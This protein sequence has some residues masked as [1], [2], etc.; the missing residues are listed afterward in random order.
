MS[1]KLTKLLALLLACMM[2]ATLFAG[3]KKAETETEQPGDTTT[4]E[5]ANDTPLVVAYSPFSEKFSPFFAD[6][7]Y[8]VDAVNMTQI[9]MLTTDRMGGIIYNAIDGEKVNYNGTDYEYKGPC[10]VTVSYD[11]SA[12]VTTYTVKLKEGIKFSDGTEATADDMLFTYYVY[13]DPDYVG[14]TTLNSYDI[15]G[16]RNYQTQTTDDIYDKYNSMFADIYAA[17]AN[18][19]VKGGES[20][21][22][23]Q[24]DLFWKTL[25]PEAWKSQIQGL[26]DYVY[27]NYFGDYWESQMPGLTYSDNLKVAF[28]MVMWGFGTLENNVLTATDT[29]KTWDLT[30]AYPSI[31]DLYDE[32]V[33]KYK[34]DPEAYF[35][36]EATGEES[37]SILAAAQ[38]NFISQAGSADPGMSGGIKS[39]SGITK[40]DNYTI[41]VKT[42]GYSAP[43]VY[44]ICG[45]NITPMHYYGDEKQWDPDNG[46]Y[47]HPFGDLSIVRG[48][49]TTP[50]GAG[51]YKFVKYENK[52]I[53]YEANENYWRGTPKIK[54]IQ[55]KETASAEVASAVASG[56]VDAGE[57][58]GSKDRFNEVKSFNSNAE[59][60]GDV[61]TTSKVDNLG[62]G[63]IGIN[64]D[65]VNVGGDQGSEASKNL[66]KALATVLAVY[67]DSAYDSYYGEAASVIQYPISNTSWAAPQPTDDGYRQ[68]YSVDAS[69]KDIYTSDMTPDQ[70]YAAAKT[71]ALGFLEAAGYTVENGKA[72][73]AP[74]GARL[75]YEVIIPADGQGDH[76]SFA[77]LT[78]AQAALAE[79]GIELKINDPADSNVLWNALDAGEQDLWCAAWQ[80]TIDPDMYQT[81]HSS[82]IVGRG[83]SDSNHYH[84]DNAD[85]DAL[86]VDARKSDDQAYRKAI[87]RQCLDIIMDYA[88]EIPAYQRQN[89]VI[90]STQRINLDTLTPDITSYW[91]WM[92]DIELLEMK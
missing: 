17:G 44:S 19:T 24:Y 56:T 38:T 62:Y 37:T 70:R 64:A 30:A 87:Y 91:G 5:P 34:G 40:V 77:V 41:E 14:S 67:R 66:R 51:A 72:V 52:V 71:A 69:G 10:N 78:D 16:L 55:F 68:A 21:T 84:I 76:P 83:G 13:L 39:V 60:S 82:G 88:V 79:I 18:Y 48:N 25:L 50:M 29:S 73:A 31:D 45:L 86:I 4:T 11:Q 27:N 74:T 12:D 46:L 43:A 7:Q 28:A 89:C 35:N 33:A 22:Q 80:S 49:T 53:Y 58:T 36:T 54:Y 90:F 81:Y 85:L 8:D 20:F 65:R 42:N 23:E 92:N 6:T 2:C 32:C 15:I 63:Y 57:M 26:V 3:C 75:S 59:I 47:G 61:I 1:K 9:S